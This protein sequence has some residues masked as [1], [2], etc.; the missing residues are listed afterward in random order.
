MILTV[1]LNPAVD[2][3]CEAGTLL[4]GEVNRLRSVCST[5]GGKGINVTKILR[6]FHLP[7]TAMGFLGGYT[8]KL[9]EDAVE[10][11]GA[12]CRFTKIKGLTRTSTNILGDDGLVTELLE[13]GPEI[14]RKELA[15]FGKEF[16]NCPE[17]CSLAVLSGSAPRGVPED[18]YARLTAG[19]QAGGG[20]VFLDAS[21]ELLKKGLEAKPYFVKPNKAELEFLAGRALDDRSA[22]EKE[23]AHLVES[24][25]KKV[26]VSLGREGLI[27]M[28]ENQCLYEPA[29]KVKTV[30]TV[31]CGDT[32]VASFVM[33]ELAGEDAGTAL[34][35]AAALAGANASTM[36]NGVIP[37]DTYLELL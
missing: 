26:V 19:Y 36:E 7:V 17:Q 6:Q 33:S 32:V 18:V 37:M 30:N 24:G 3:I 5:A 15:A 2:K 29:R 27:Y 13:P 34:K 25:I 12:E 21:G 35:K 9:I 8:G 20:K 1:T 31:G 4:P 10:E 22:V 16:L 28:D 14:S 23:A 11:L